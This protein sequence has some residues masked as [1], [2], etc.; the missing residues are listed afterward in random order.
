M[1]GR[2]RHISA[3]QAGVW[4]V[5]RNQNIYYR[6]KKRWLHVGG[7]LKQIDSGPRGIVCGVNKYDN[8][9]CRLQV[10]SRCRQ[11]RRWVRVPGKLKYISC[12]DYGHWGVNKANDIYFREGVSRSNPGGLKWQKIPGKLKQ[13][14]AGQY[15]QVWGV[16]RLGRVYVRTG[17]TQQMPWGKGWK[18][19]KTVK[20]WRRVTIGIGAVYGVAKNGRVY[21]TLPATGG[22][23]PRPPA[24][25]KCSLL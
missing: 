5:N 16:N 6:A 25:G 21:R 14:E 1:G 12:G 4:G 13:I 2:L 8:I 7:K 23:T 11:G 22:V 19:V 9:Y 3:G 10:S 17:V 18:K 24:K 20:A 15:G